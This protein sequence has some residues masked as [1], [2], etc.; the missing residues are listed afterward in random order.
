MYI[1]PVRE[2]KL[3][4]LGFAQA[5]AFF[6]IHKRQFVLVFHRKSYNAFVKCTGAAH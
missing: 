2:L 4:A 1:P 5:A 6:S 3:T